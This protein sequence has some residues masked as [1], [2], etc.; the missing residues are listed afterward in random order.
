MNLSANLLHFIAFAVIAVVAYRFNPMKVRK[1]MLL[2]FN[3]AFYYLCSPKYLIVMLFAGLWSY[4][5][6]KKIDTASNRKSAALMGIIPLVALLCAFK[7]WMPIEI[8]LGGIGG[9]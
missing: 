6:G 1:Y 5:C 7:Y 4:F 8:L 2:G 9:G 3:L